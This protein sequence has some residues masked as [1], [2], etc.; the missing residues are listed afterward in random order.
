VGAYDEINNSVHQVNTDKEKDNNSKEFPGR[1]IEHG[2]EQT[3]PRK[4]R[5]SFFAE[6]E[7]TV[8]VYKTAPVAM[9][10]GPKPCIIIGFSG[11]IVF[12]YRHCVND[13]CAKLQENSN[14]DVATESK[15]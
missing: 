11:R 2:V 9:S 4:E 3:D 6:I 1:K 7:R 15:E 8:P 12:P 14:C 5:P 10:I 13:L